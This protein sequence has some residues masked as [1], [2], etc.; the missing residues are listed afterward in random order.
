MLRSTG[1]ISRRKL[2]FASGALIVVQT[3]P[4]VARAH[5]CQHGYFGCSTNGSEFEKLIDPN[6]SAFS[7]VGNSTRVS[8]SGDRSFDVALA[9]TLKYLSVEF[10]VLPGFTFIRE[11]AE[12]NA[13]AT[14]QDLLGRSDGTVAFGL[15]MIDRVKRTSDHWPASVAGICAHEFSH[16][17]QYKFGAFSRLGV[18]EKTA[19]RVEL[20]A[21]FLAGYFAGRRKQT[22]P[23]FPA[24]DVART[25]FDV[26]D[27]AVNNP[28]HHG[29]PEER[30]A[31]VIEGF[32]HADLEFH[33]SYERGVNY[34][35]HV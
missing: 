33:D 27:H 34:A 10:S 26:G 3:F 31:A 18:A 17:A 1:T 19:R 6:P 15:K 5:C 21:D 28:T 25:F 23:R 30:A 32:K 16:I 14:N 8:G 29:T 2:L 11:A 22:N 7:F 4:S 12:A 24:A 13:F 35:L 9:Q 20:H